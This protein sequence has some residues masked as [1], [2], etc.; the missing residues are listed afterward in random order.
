MTGFF[1][2]DKTWL[3]KW[4]DFLHTENRG[5]HLLYSDWLQSYKS[6]GFDFEVFIVIENELII[7]GFGAVIAK[8]LIFKFYI[9]PVGPIFSEG[10]ESRLSFAIDEIESRAKKMSCCY[11]QFRLPIA[12]NLKIQNKLYLPNITSF[13]KSKYRPGNFFKYVYCPNGLN[14]VGFENCNSSDDLLIK[15]NVQVRRNINLS[16]KT[17]TEISYAVTFDECRKA[18]AMIELN[19]KQNNYDVRSFA[20]FSG[21]ICNLIDKKL[22]FFM[23]A[24]LNNQIKGVAFVVNCG[25][26]LTY[27]S[28]GTSKEKPDLKIGYLLHWEIIKKSFEM[29]FSGYNISLGGSNGVVDFKSKFNTETILYADETRFLILKSNYFKLYLLLNSFFNKNKKVISGIL[30]MIK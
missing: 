30:K 6:Y 10:F 22:A 12:E 1:T 17:P 14:W 18:Y 15:F 29:G 4:D 19:A 24:K 8:S 13:D 20:D 9:V 28:G 16:L 21:T 11:L 3:S 25:N 2:K 27:I 5:S 26:H 7:G 23:V